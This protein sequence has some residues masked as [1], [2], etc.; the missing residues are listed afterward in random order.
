MIKKWGR[1]A[2][3]LG[4]FLVPNLSYAH[5]DFTKKS[6]IDHFFFAAL[7]GSLD[8][9]NALTSATPI[10]EEIV[11]SDG[12]LYRFDFKNDARNIFGTVGN[13]VTPWL[14]YN[15]TLN[16]LF[17]ATLRY[18]GTQPDKLTFAQF[19][20]LFSI[21]KHAFDGKT[22]SVKDA[23]ST[24]LKGTGFNQAQAKSDL[25]SNG[26]TFTDTE[27]GIIDG[28]SRLPEI[29][30]TLDAFKKDVA[31]LKKNKSSLAHKAFH[32]IHEILEGENAG[33]LQKINLPVSDGNVPLGP[34]DYSQNYT[35]KIPAATIST[36]SLD[37]LGRK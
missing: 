13:S 30:L 27:D 7:K 9:F 4:T 12:R 6:D 8:Q 35:F 18:Q 17:A 29:L 33:C 3:L 20:V 32:K 14:K 21:L 24:L 31:D 26:V 10:Q 25:T 23:L 5:P 1:T 28:L 36:F 22:I 11:L 2:L 37:D 16:T 34:V 19:K 15:E